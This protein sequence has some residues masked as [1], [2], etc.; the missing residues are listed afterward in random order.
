MEANLQGIIMHWINVY[1]GLQL[2]EFLIINGSEQVT[3]EARKRIYDVKGCETY[4]YVDE[5]KKD[6]GINSK[7]FID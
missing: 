4:H 7:I 1:Q 2:L 3:D 5:K 6:Q